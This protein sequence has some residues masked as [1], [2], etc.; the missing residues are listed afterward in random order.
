MFVCVCASVRMRG[1]PEPL[2]AVSGESVSQTLMDCG[3]SLRPWEKQREPSKPWELQ[4]RLGI[5][6]NPKTCSDGWGK[7]RRTGTCKVV[8][9]VS[10]HK[11]LERER[12]KKA[13]AFRWQGLLKD[14]GS[15]Y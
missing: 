13:K 10:H 1:V 11:P 4:T 15:T 5:G 14:P 7:W 3:A 12:E 9:F 8:A 6:Q 2:A